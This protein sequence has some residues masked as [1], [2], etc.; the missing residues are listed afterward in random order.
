MSVVIVGVN[1]KTAP[2][3]VRE[4]LSMD[5]GTVRESLKILLGECGIKE[6]LVLCTC[7]RVEIMV[8][9]TAVHQS[10]DAIKSLL[11][12]R[13]G[14][15]SMVP[16]E[17]VYSM[18]DRD[19][20]RHLFS[21]ASS[22]D[23]MVLGEPQILGQVKEAYRISVE[24]KSAGPMLNRVL[25]H[26]FRACKR[27]RTETEIGRHAV[28]VSYAAV[29]LARNIFES[30]DNKS[31]LLV[32]AG[33]MVELAAQHFV[34][35]GVRRLRVANR[36][37]SRAQELASQFRG[38]AIPFDALMAHL[39]DADIVLSCTGASEYVIG[40]EDVRKAL[41]LRRN[42]PIF[43][44][45][46]AVPRDVDPRVNELENAYLYDIDDIQKVV[47]RNLEHR[48]AEIDKAQ[49]IVDG[50]VAQ[51][52]AWFRSLEAEPTIKAIRRMA[53]EVRKKEMDRTLSHLPGLGDN[54]RQSLD[55]MTNAIVNKI[56]HPAMSRLKRESGKDGAGLYVQVTRE[57]FGLDGGKEEG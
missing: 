42:R 57:L 2:V 14:K 56:L 22:L 5:E 36:T 27:V 35:R 4:S 39:S 41:R 26:A 17:F 49:E 18:V 44:I 51:F 20:V 10:I 15:E 43:F 52:V 16:D 31:I 34:Q 1:H 12:D 33:E 6:A 3:E 9:T 47:E 37:F 50:E 48:R 23:S 55:A 46:I 54:E 32:G 30:L 45:D 40:S 11:R 8:Y 21:V 7:N 19:A 53:D 28:S 25:H 38:E 13:A 24:S 29:E